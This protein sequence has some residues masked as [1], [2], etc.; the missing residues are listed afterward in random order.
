MPDQPG[1]NPAQYFRRNSGKPALLGIGRV[2]CRLDIGNRA[3]FINDPTQSG[4][5]AEPLV[6]IVRVKGG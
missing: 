2:E 4:P 5:F 6:N 3:E 1:D